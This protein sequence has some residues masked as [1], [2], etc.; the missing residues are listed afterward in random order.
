MTTMK[1]IDVTHLG[2]VVGIM[3][4]VTNYVM[5]LELI[6]LIYLMFVVG[7]YLRLIHIRVTEK[8]KVI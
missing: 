5:S 7:C 3:I 4:L 8:Q 2:F 1:K 6:D